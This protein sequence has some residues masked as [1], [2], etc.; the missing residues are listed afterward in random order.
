M[1]AYQYIN[2]V[3][4]HLVEKNGQ[5]SDPIFTQPPI[6]SSRK[7]GIIDQLT[8][9]NI[10]DQAAVFLAAI[11]GVDENQNYALPTKFTYLR[12]HNTII[13]SC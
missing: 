10:G 2:R 9:F 3:F 4:G 11:I 12:S 7:I 8:S 6:C 13:I 5:G 1:Q